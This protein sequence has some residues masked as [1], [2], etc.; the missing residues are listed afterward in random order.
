MGI[1]RGGHLKVYDFGSV[2]HRDD[3]GF[4]VQVLDDHFSLANAI[5]YLAA[6]VD[7]LS[8]ATSYSKFRQ[9]EDELR[10]GNAAVE[11]EARDLEQVIR[12]G[13]RRVPQSAPSFTKLEKHVA[14]IRENDIIIRSQSPSET[15]LNLGGDLPLKF[16]GETEKE[17][18]WIDE[19][20]YSAAWV[21]KGYTLPI[22]T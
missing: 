17:P 10:Q 4:D 8:K 18:Q 3:E 9:I 16:L 13:W 7:P 15:P 5:R 20:T 14:D 19:D 2:V 1:D 11:D 22:R 6:G 12:A 21:A